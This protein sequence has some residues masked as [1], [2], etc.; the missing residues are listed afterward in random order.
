[1]E[2][3]IQTQNDRQRILEMEK[4]VET[5]FVVKR[6]EKEKNAELIQKNLEKRKLILQKIR[7]LQSASL[8]LNN[9]CENYFKEVKNQ[10]YLRN[11]I[12]PSSSWL[13][14]VEVENLFDSW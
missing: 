4:N 8:Y 6:Q 3:K 2:T 7:S 12:F 14:E 13:I 9:F 5:D 1:M 10:E 11:S